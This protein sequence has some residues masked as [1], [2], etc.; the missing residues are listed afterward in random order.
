MKKDFDN[1]NILKQEIEVTDKIVYAN[2]RDIWWAN[3]GINIGSEICGKNNIFERPVLVLKI[4]T[5]DLILIAPLT[6][7]KKETKNHIEIKFDDKISF[8]MLEHLKT[9]S[10]KRLSRKIRKINKEEF[11]KIYKY[12]KE[13][14]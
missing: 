13:N 8:V 14:F 10:T 4:F 3:I 1:W 7:Q 11:D 6:T 9:I 2:K 12:M 5:K